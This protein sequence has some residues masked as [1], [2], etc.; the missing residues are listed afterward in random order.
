MSA[1][2]IAVRY[3]KALFEVALE[4]GKLERVLQDIR[5]FEKLCQVREFYLL[6]KSPIIKA[7][8]KARILDGLIKG[9]FDELTIKFIHLLVRKG[10]ERYLSEIAQAFI[11]EYKHYKHIVTVKVTSAVPLSQATLDKICQRLKEVGLVKGE[12]ELITKVDPTLIGGVQI[13]FEGKRIDATVAHQL[14][15]VAR[16]FKDNLYISQ[17]IAS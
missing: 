4:Q 17:I 3:A 9:H 13:E 7:D 6:L 14:D 8:K 16:E 11:E 5:A 10:R 2:R 15:K 1:H 12:I